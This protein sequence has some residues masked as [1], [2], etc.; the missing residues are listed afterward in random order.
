[1][2]KLEKSIED[3]KIKFYERVGKNIKISINS[4]ERVKLSIL[5]FYHFGFIAFFIPQF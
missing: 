2:I 4:F 3:L 5:Q 1:M